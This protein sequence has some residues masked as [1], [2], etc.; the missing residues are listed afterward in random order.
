MIV[1]ETVDGF[2]FI[3]QPDHAALAGQFADAWGNDRFE[4]AD[5]RAAVALAAHTHDDG[6]GP[7]DRRPHLHD[8]GSPVDFY[9]LDAE[10][11]TDLYERG[12]DAVAE[13]DPY[14]GLL[15]SMHGS[16]LRRRRYGL[17]PEWPDTP[18]AFAAFVER[19][20]RRQRELLGAID[21]RVDD[22]DA[23]LLDA[24]HETGTAPPDTASTLWTHYRLLQAWDALSLS[25]CTTVD[26]PGSP[27][28]ASVPTGPGDPEETLHTERVDADRFQ[29][30]PW[31]FETET[32]DVSVPTRTVRT[33]AFDD[34]A[35]LLDAY[36]AA[37]LDRLTLTLQSP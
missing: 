26:P 5:P 3:T 22:E 14:A 23:H 27:A 19:E 33:D 20:E 32:L 13:L 35:E 8:D 29:V 37:G 25:F 18:E 10:P 31:P 36:Y 12:I 1:A 2:R 11:W 9:E 24:I 4:L 30:S 34:E 6:W 15:V 28:V 7:Y 21:D 17:S 16:G